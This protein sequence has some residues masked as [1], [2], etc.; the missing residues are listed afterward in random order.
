MAGSEPDGGSGLV[1]H[2]LGSRVIPRYVDLE[3]EEWLEYREQVTTWEIDRYLP[4][5]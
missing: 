1:E 4:L 3:R 2:A 5:T